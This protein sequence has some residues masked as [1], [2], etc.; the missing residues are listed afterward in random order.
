MLA[1]VGVLPCENQLFTRVNGSPARLG[2]GK[3][4]SK[5]CAIL[6][7]LDSGMMF[8]GMG[9]RSVAPLASTNVLYGSKIGTRA[10]LFRRVS[11]KSPASCCAVG[12]LAVVDVAV[13]L[14]ARS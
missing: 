3:Y 11:E 2:A 13:K 7:C 8:P 1:A 14:L 5:F 6:F 9:L 12:T 4:L 10:P